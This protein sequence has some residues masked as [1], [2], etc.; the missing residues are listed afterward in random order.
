MSKRCTQCG[1]F[2][3]ETDRFCPNCGENAP[4]ELNESP[5][6]TSTSSAM[7]GGTQTSQYNQYNSN[8]YTQPSPQ[9]YT[10]SNDPQ[11]S[12]YQAQD[13]ELT[14]GKCLLTLFVST[15][16]FIGIIFLFIWGFGSGPKSRQNLCRA[17]LIFYAVAIVLLTFL[18]V[19]LV[20]IGVNFYDMAEAEYYNHY[21]GASMAKNIVDM[22]FC[23]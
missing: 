4:Q 8:Q 12:P 18:S 7:Q 10:P 20:I 9:P 11:Y 17:I 1:T 22:F 23:R 3:T 15:L 16:G 14:V 13:E 2:L 19:F 21:Y 6:Y 5:I